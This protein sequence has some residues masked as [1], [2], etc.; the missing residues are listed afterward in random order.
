MSQSTVLCGKT[1]LK[2]L[3]QAAKAL[4]GCPPLWE[5]RLFERELTE[6]IKTA[7]EQY[8]TVSENKII[9]GEKMLSLSDI[10]D[11]TVSQLIEELSQSSYIGVGVLR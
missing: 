7:K 11:S 4:K 5:N 2:E 8:I 6:L 1:L 10:N 9:L 3:R